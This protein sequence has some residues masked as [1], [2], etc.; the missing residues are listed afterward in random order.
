MIVAHCANGT[1]CT[2]S[3]DYAPSRAADRALL[4]L[5]ARA[6]SDESDF[7]RFYLDEFTD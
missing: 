5:A 3:D 6:G 2:C 1:A 7:S 4:D